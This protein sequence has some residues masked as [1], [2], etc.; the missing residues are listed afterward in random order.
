MTAIASS[1][2]TATITA[3]PTYE[4]CG[5]PLGGDPESTEEPIC[6]VYTPQ[7]TPTASPTATATSE[8]FQIWYVACDVSGGY[9]RAR[10]YPTLDGEVIA[11]IPAGTVLYGFEQRSDEDGRQW[12]RITGYEAAT[13]DT[14]LWSAIASDGITNLTQIEPTL[15]ST[16][17]AFSTPVALS[18]ITPYPTTTATAL[19]VILAPSPCPNG[20]TCPLSGTQPSDL[21]IVSFV[22]ACEGGVAVPIANSARISDALAIAHVIYNRMTSAT[23]HSSA[24]DVVRQGSGSVGQF[25]CYAEGAPSSLGLNN[26]SALSVL[27]VEIRAAAQSLV[28]GQ[29]PAD[30]P[31]ATM[32]GRVDYYGLYT[33]GVYGD[34]TQAA[35][36]P[37]PVAELLDP[38]CTNLPLT[39]QLFVAIAPFGSGSVNTTAYFSDFHNCALQ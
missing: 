26:L 29:E 15:Q 2:P 35:M 3:T 7:P 11:N 4:G 36:T 32:D 8:P 31:P 25:Q 22:L 30:L 18:S 34:V 24:A 37:P 27:P 39:L 13:H 21:D 9:L 33:F 17:C 12:L 28:N 10:N 23:F 14:T 38:Y 1:T 20:R 19:P 16:P 6:Y 5:L